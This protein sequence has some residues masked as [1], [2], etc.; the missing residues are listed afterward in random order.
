M[1]KFYYNLIFGIVAACFIGM[2]ALI[3]VTAPERDRLNKQC[4]SK[5]G[6]YIATED[7]GFVCVDRKAFITIK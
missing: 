6:V 7:I 1:S 5:G 2:L 3:L 4:I